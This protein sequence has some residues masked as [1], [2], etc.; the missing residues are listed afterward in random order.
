MMPA[1]KKTFNLMADDIVEVSVENESLKTQIGE[2]DEK[3][4][5]GS[6]AKVLNEFN[7]E[8]RANLIMPRKKKQMNK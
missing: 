6:K 1:I 8:N 3:W 5:Q 2:L 4:F 7:D